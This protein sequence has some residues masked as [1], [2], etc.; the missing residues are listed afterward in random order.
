MLDYQQLEALNAVV[1]AGSFNRASKILHITQPAISQKIQQLEESLGSPVLLRT[2]PPKLTQTGRD[3]IEHI[4]KVKLLE[5][6][7]KHDDNIE[8]SLPTIRIGVNA[9]SIVTWFFQVIAPIIQ[10]EKFLVEILVEDET[11]THELLRK[12]EVFGCVSAHNKP[13]PGCECTFIG[14]IPYQCISTKEFKEHY[15]KKGLSTKSVKTAPA[16]IFNNIDYIHTNFLKS[17]LKIK[18]VNYPF[19]M[20]PSSEGFYQAI[21]NGCAYGLVPYKQAKNDLEN[22]KVIYLTP[23]NPFNIKLYWHYKWKMSKKM[24][25]LKELFV[26]DARMILSKG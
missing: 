1:T 24:S 25:S 19:H 9:D 4:R 22:K 7:L 6:E 2:T 26:K 16:V 11:I 15:F 21:K 20:V 17:F 18:E 5:S 8:Q 3:L 12:G 23:N 10:Q 13:L 14:N